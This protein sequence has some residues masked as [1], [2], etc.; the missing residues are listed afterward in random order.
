MKKPLRLL[1]V[2]LGTIP[3]G[4]F[5]RGTFGRQATYWL[6]GGLFACAIFLTLLQLGLR[7]YVKAQEA[8]MS[9]EERREFEQFKKDH[10]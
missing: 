9:P 6:I 4:Y 7:R 5:F 8:K 1:L 10:T 3:L 2:V